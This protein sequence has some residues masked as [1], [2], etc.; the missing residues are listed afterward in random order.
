MVVT[1]ITPPAFTARR[2]QRRSRRGTA[3]NVGERRF[4]A[5]QK[6]AGV[7]IALVLGLGESDVK[8]A[9]RFYSKAVVIR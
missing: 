5:R 6:Q 1:L 4:L 9:P 3:Y 7:H 8:R 2:S